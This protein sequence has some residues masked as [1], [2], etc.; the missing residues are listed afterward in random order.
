MMEV[1]SRWQQFKT[2]NHNTSI[3]KDT[4][5][6]KHASSLASSQLISYSVYSTLDKER[7]SKQWSWSSYINKSHENLPLT[8]L[9]ANLVY[10]FFLNT[11]L[12]RDSKLCPIGS[13]Q[14]T[15]L[16]RWIR[17]GMMGRTR[18]ERTSHKPRTVTL[19]NPILTALRMN[20]PCRFC[21]V[22]SCH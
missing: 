1:K 8:N 11:H 9:Q 13:S 17:D 2:T 16:E 5:R 12:P 3:V 21:T 10:Q 7:N 4:E 22:C 6:C 18:K 20:N 14:N 19:R 15:V